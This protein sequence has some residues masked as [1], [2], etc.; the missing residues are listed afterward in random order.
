MN[1]GLSDELKLSFP[2]IKPIFRPLLLNKSM[3]S[4]NWIA[5]LASGDGCF[6]V[7]I[8]NSPYN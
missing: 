2:K 5:G 7:S 3:I 6:H 4:P 1:R 8:R